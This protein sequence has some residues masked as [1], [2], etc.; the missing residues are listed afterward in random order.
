MSRLQ[1]LQSQLSIDPEDR[2]GMLGQ[3]NEGVQKQQA[4]LSAQVDVTAFHLLKQDICR[5]VWFVKAN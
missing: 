4:L 2:R 1:V 3:P 5:S